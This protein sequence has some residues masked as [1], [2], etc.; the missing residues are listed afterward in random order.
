MMDIIYLI[1]NVNNVT[2]F[3]LL[4]KFKQII[5]HH[6]TIVIVRFVKKRQD[7]ILMRLKESVM[8]NVVMVYL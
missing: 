1:M 7:Y 5:V 3:V 6:F 2:V 8:Q 4:V